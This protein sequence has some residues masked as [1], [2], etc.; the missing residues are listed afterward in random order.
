MKQC[1][2]SSCT[3]MDQHA[4]AWTAKAPRDPQQPR[5]Y[6]SHTVYVLIGFRLGCS[7]PSMFNRDTFFFYSHGRTAGVKPGLIVQLHFSMRSRL[8]AMGLAL[9]CMQCLHYCR[10]L[11]G[12]EVCSK[13]LEAFCSYTLYCPSFIAKCLCSSTLPQWQNTSLQVS[14]SQTS[15]SHAQNII[16][17]D[18]CHE[19]SPVDTGS[20]P[21]RYPGNS[22]RG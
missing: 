5:K 20:P 17:M 8:A 4:P 22:E 13:N 21:H 6:T 16:P 7:G 1:S 10:L 15:V 12:L 2:Q 11:Y 18:M 3:H 19:P 14:G 9:L